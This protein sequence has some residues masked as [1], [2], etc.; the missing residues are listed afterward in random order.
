MSIVSTA[1]IVLLLLLLLLIISVIRSDGHSEYKDSP[2]QYVL[3]CYLDFYR[4]FFLDH[5]HHYRN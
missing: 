4:Y 3:Y 1:A 2:P 5:D